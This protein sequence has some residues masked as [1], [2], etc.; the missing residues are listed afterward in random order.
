[1]RNEI[2]TEVAHAWSAIA[3]DSANLNEVAIGTDNLKGFPLEFQSH[4][5]GGELDK[6][7]H[8]GASGDPARSRGNELSIRFPF[9]IQI[10]MAL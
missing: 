7:A 9:K 8:A 2:V 5:I 3:A 10:S 1:M 4:S 6:V